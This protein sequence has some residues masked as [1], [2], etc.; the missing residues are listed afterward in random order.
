V[1]VTYRTANDL[2]LAGADYSSAIERIVIRAG[3]TS[4]TFGVPVLGDTVFEPRETFIVSLSDP[5]NATIARG[6]AF[7]IINDN[8]TPAGLQLPTDHHFPWQWSLVSPYSI[9]VLPAWNDYDGT[10]VRVAVFDQGIDVTHAD[11]DGNVLRLS[12]RDAATFSGEGLPRATSDNHGTA[13]AGVIAAERDG[14]GT[15]GVAYNADLIS[16]YS[17]LNESPFAFGVTAANAF[18]Y[19]RF[20]NADVVNNSW[21]FGNYFQF[22]P[23]YA[24][25]DD[26]GSSVFAAAGRELKNLA[27]SGRDGLGT[28]VVQ[29]AGNSFEWGDN[30]NL[31]GFQNSRYTITVAA[32]DYF[33][34]A[35][36]YSSPGASILVTAPGGG[37]SGASGI[38][39]TDRAG[40]VGYV[41]SDYVFV[42]GTS[43]SS[44]VASGTVALILQANPELGYRDVQEILA[45]SAVRLPQAGAQWEF[46]GAANW[47]G[48][49][50]H[51]NS[52]VHRFGFGLID[53]TAAVRLAETW[54]A[55]HTV[56]NLE[57]VTGS[58]APHAPIPDANSAGIEDTLVVDSALRVERVDVSL[59]IA[60]TF[61]GDLTVELTSPGG[62]TSTL[63][64]HPGQGR[65]STTGSAQQ[66]IDFTFDTVAYWGEQAEGAWTLHVTDTGARG[67][68][69]LESWSMTLAGKP[70]SQDDTYI[71]TN[72][73]AESALLQS[74]R[75]TLTDS[76]GVD[77]LNAAAVS[78][79]SRIDLTPG[80]GST[81]AGTAL[82]IDRD[83]LI[84]HA[85]GGDG[86]DTIMGNASNNVLRGM[87]GDDALFGADGDDVLEGGNGS[88]ELNGGMGV[89]TAVFS[90]SRAETTLARTHDGY[91]VTVDDG[92]DSLIEI[93]RL[94]FTDKMI[95]LDLR[96]TDAGGKAA[97]VIGAA[98]DGQHMDAA[99][100]GVAVSLFD[101]GY[102][103]LEVADLAIQS[104]LFLSR[105]GSHGNVEFVNTVYRNVMGVTPDAAE[106][107]F[108]VGL[109]QGSG[110]TMTQ[111][112]LLALAANADANAVNID[113]AGLQQSGL[114]FA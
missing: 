114:E 102:S 37:T 58:R 81:I 71:Y 82:L 54:G 77:T 30:T 41:T 85:T 53:A 49:G 14:R 42:A 35:A 111:A 88:D 13:I 18:A 109:L 15:V 105:A 7:G 75:T 66:N 78:T 39:T 80:A 70:A 8:D 73:Y 10:G 108:Y 12:G 69:T 113:L 59:E 110:G 5:S 43:F 61:I 11:L 92:S 72:E 26:F 21:G 29:S 1:A 87:R 27:A 95:A 101:T 23:N 63:L 65:L 98:F 22:D 52:G 79:A 99:V 60:H 31:H 57:E 86:N 45:Y 20:S 24:F 90:F 56:A 47:N 2:G 48:G 84:E 83:A 50:L 51:F 36:R 74:A 106:R 4:A 94:N 33:G 100:L 104:N 91:T 17:P 3:N 76:G 44:A 9:N 107:D 55:S 16:I 68:G 93:E 6:T 34:S 64:Y 97:R 25:L 46:N 89:D 40:S 112:D 62:I 103:L 38:V 96:A 67:T 28:V 19:A 32:S